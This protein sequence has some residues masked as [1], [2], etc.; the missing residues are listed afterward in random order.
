YGDHQ[1][2]DELTARVPMILRWPELGDDH[3]GRVDRGFHYQFDVAASVLELLGARVPRSWDGRSFAPA[4][5]EGREEGRD[6]LIVSQAAWTCQRSV[7]WDDWIG[8]RT[9]HDGYHAFP[10]WMLFDV[11]KD[12]HETTDLA[13]ENS[14]VIEQAATRLDAWYDEMAQP[15]DPMQTVM[16]EGGPFHTRGQLARYV[17]RL[18]E[19]EREH[20]A[21]ALEERH[22]SEL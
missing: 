9:Y 17:Q 12:P 20:W 4:L 18:R 14:G 19:T 13:S 3:A 15:E 21:R 10:E 6:E 5:R 22:P 2:A 16:R 8:I 1:T 7:R 11:A